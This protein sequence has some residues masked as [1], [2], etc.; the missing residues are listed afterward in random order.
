[1]A[2][3]CQFCFRWLASRNAPPWDVSGTEPENAIYRFLLF[4]MACAIENGGTSLCRA[5]ARRLR[6]GTT[7]ASSEV[8]DSGI[9]AHQW[10][11]A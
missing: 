10:K 3:T 2:G 6:P 5:S 4:S 9:K 11:A 7:Y 8:V 1:M